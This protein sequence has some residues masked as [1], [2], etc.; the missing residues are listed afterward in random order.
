M[1][2]PNVNSFESQQFNSTVKTRIDQQVRKSKT[3]NENEDKVPCLLCNDGKL[4]NRQSG[5]KI[6]CK[7]RHKNLRIYVR[8]TGFV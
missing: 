6:H 5:L 1:K 4:Y 8:P 2:E 3:V 7:R